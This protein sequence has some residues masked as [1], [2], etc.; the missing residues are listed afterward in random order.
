MMINA[1]NGKRLGS[2]V[3]VIARE[4]GGGAVFVC[5][6]CGNGCIFFALFRRNNCG[7]A[8]G[9][10]SWQLAVGSLCIGCGNR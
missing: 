2:P 10:C 6:C 8:S 9:N 7:I 1:Q 4:A 3:M 5:G